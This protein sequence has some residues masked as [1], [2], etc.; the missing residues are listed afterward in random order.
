[1]KSIII[2]GASHGIGAAIARRFAKENYQLAICARNAKELK[3]FSKELLLLGA[4]A[5]F[6][7][8]VDVSDKIS[9]KSFAYYALEQLKNLSILVNNAGCFEPGTIA[10]EEEGQLEKMLQTNLLSAY[11]ITRVLLPHF[12]Q[13]KQGHI[14]N[15]CSVAS[16]KAYPN[17]GSYSISKY[18][19]LGFSDNLREELKHDQIKVSAIC[20]GATNSR[21][22][23][24]ANVP[25]ERLMPAE[26]IAETVW[27]LCQLSNS[28]V[29]ENVIL[30]PQFGDL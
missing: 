29:L 17:G 6:S 20:P 2:T 23:S 19:L 9:A 16:L 11:N 13:K 10:D 27:T 18:A 28:T 5:V 7:M 21:S 25:K 8:P 30:R 26:D 15:I 22:W 1:M 24:G 12:K 4:S 3:L 14:V